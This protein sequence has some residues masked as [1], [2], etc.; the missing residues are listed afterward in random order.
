MSR[1]ACTQTKTAARRAN[2]EH[3]CTHSSNR[4]GLLLPT[5]LLPT[6]LL[7]LP[8]LL[9]RVPR[10]FAPQPPHRQLDF[11]VMLACSTNPAWPSCWMGGWAEAELLLWLRCGLPAAGHQAARCT[12]ALLRN[13][14]SVA[15]HTRHTGQ[16]PQWWSCCCEQM[17]GHSS[18]V[19][20]K[21]LP[22]LLAGCVCPNC[23]ECLIETQREQQ[24][25][26]QVKDLKRAA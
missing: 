4:Y 13:P 16:P 25:E 5:L 1:C 24:K 20:Q 10:L 7:L 6:T 19:L 8:T 22:R 9:L 18:P 14:G 17:N 26:C 11:Q 23:C 12:A 3:Y 2:S 15:Q 21:L